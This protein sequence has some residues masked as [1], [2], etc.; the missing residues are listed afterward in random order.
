MSITLAIDSIGVLNY[1]FIQSG[2][3]LINSITVTNIGEEDIENLSIVLS[4][5]FGYIESFSSSIPAVASQSFHEVHP[6]LSFHSKLI[7]ELTERVIDQLTCTVKREEEVLTQTTL[8]IAVLPIQQWSGTTVIPESLACYALPN[9]PEV[10]LIVARAAE[11]LKQ[12]TGNPSFTGYLSNDKNRVLEQVSAIYAAIYELNIVYSVLPASF[13]QVGQR[14]RLPNEVY[15]IKQA[16]CIEMSLLFSSVCE[17][18]GLHPFITVITGHAFA[19]VWLNDELFDSSLVLDR[20]ELTK[21]LAKGINDLEIFE[22]TC[23]NQASGK[24]FDQAIRIAHRHLENPENFHFA[25]DI[26]RCHLLGL[27]PLPVKSV[28]NGEIT[29]IDYGYAKDVEEKSQLKQKL[30]D[31]FLDTSQKE[32]INKSTIWMRNLLDLSRRNALISFRPNMKSLQLFTSDLDSLEDALSNGDSFTLTE[33]TGSLKVASKSNRMLD[34]ENEKEFIAEIS[35]ADFKAKMIRTFMEENDMVSVLKSIYRENQKSIEENG[36]S[37]LF[38]ALGFLKWF[39]PKEN[40]SDGPNFRYAP[41]VLVPIDLTRKSLTRYQIRLRDEDSQMNITLLEY[42]RQQFNLSINGLNPLPE[43]EAG[44]DI[45]LIFNSIRKAIIQQKGWDILDTAVLG[46]FSFSQFVMW[47]DLKERFDQLTSNKVVKGLVD[48]IYIEPNRKRIDEED[49]DKEFEAKELLIPSPVDSSQ[50]AAIAE[51]NSQQSFVLHGPPGTGKSQTITNMIANSLYHGKSILFVA[52][53][54]AALNVVY[55]RLAQIGLEDFCLEIHSNKTSKRVVL[56]K[57]EHSLQ[58]KPDKQLSQFTKLGQQVQGVRKK[59]NQQLSELHL[60]RAVGLSIYELISALDA[61]NCDFPRLS[62]N[63]SQLLLLNA[64]SL[65]Q[66]QNQLTILAT[67]LAEATHPYHS[68]P[69]KDFTNHTYSSNGESSLRKCIENL[70]TAIA[71]LQPYCENA[72]LTQLSVFRQ[73]H[74]VITER[75]LKT[76]LSENSWKLLLDPDYFAKLQS[77]I[78]SNIEFSQLKKKIRSRYSDDIHHINLVA[79]RTDYTK[80]IGRFLM[81]KGK[82]KQALLPLNV[83]CKNGFSLSEDNAEQEFATLAQYLDLYKEKNT[84]IQQFETLVGIQLDPL[85]PEDALEDIEALFTKIYM[86][87]EEYRLSEDSLYQHYCNVLKSDSKNREELLQNLDLVENE[88][89]QFFQLTNYSLNPFFMQQEGCNQLVNLFDTWS[90]ALTHWKDWSHLNQTFHSIKELGLSSLSDELRTLLINQQITPTQIKDGCLQAIQHRLIELYIQKSPTLTSFNRLT[91]QNAIDQYNT[92]LDKVEDESKKQIRQALISRIP[93]TE[94]ASVEQQKQLAAIQKIIRSKG[95]GTSIRKIFQENGSIIKQLTPCLLMSPLSVAQ[96][97]DLDFPKFDLVIFDEASQIPTG[98]AIGAMSRADNC[99]IVGDPKQMPPTA[100]FSNQ[101]LDEENIQLEDLESL[102][103]DCLAI[104]MPQKYLSCHYRS[105]SESLISFSNRMYYGNKMMTFPSP[106]DSQSKV[107]LRSIDGIYKRG[108]SRTN[109]QEAEAIV[110][111]IR[112]R[113]EGPDF[114]QESI[115]VVTFNSTQQELI[116]DLLQKLF[117]EQPELEKRAGQMAEPIFI[118]NLENVQG[119][120]RD[121]IL[122][123]ITYGPDAD[124]KFYQNFGPLGK[125]GGW[126]RLNVAVSRARKEMIVFSSITS[127]DISVVA[128]TSE[129]VIGLKTFLKFAKTGLD[130]FQTKKTEKQTHEQLLSTIQVFLAKKGYQSQLNFGASRF[131]LDLVVEHPTEKGTFLATILLDGHQLNQLHTARDRNRLLPTI[132]SAK[133]WHTFRIWTL[134]YFENQERVLHDLLDFLEKIGPKPA[135][136]APNNVPSHLEETR[137][138]PHEQEPKLTQVTPICSPVTRTA[139]VVSQPI[140]STVQ[141]EPV[142]SLEP[143]KGSQKQNI[144]EETYSIYQ[145]IESEQLSIKER[146]PKA[147]TALL[148]RIVD[149]EA[150]ILEELVMKRAIELSTESK[151]TANLRDYLQAG[152][153]KVKSKKTKED[154]TTVYFGQLDPKTYSSF[155]TPAGQERRDFYLIPLV[156]IANAMEYSLM[157]QSDATLEKNLFEDAQIISDT[158][159]LFGFART[160]E[161]MS[162]RAEAALQNLAKKKRIK[163]NRNKAT[164]HI[165]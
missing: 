162:L 52:E 40:S 115:G 39:D 102:L 82:V 35:R 77:I 127:E 75:N 41:L 27:R 69:L 131:Q 38:L 7:F 65:D 14:L 24:S 18:V 4:S 3:P 81:K 146:E 100:F 93:D 19:G 92:L 67:Q 71:K 2:I 62:L 17:N 91:Q 12:K 61:N 45:R 147:L 148:Q 141:E 111:E 28:E 76:N 97:I 6:R 151:L 90:A 159:R 142:S 121:S 126:R 154:S 10:S 99:I 122:F 59:L 105:K 56:D 68:H 125:K 106:S 34:I 36:A 11:L 108:E 158:V 47:N 88:V 89:V 156:E 132:L 83:L 43:D 98:I 5:E 152:L 23:M 104:N 118:K 73:I 107:S 139:L 42:L 46:H 129:G 117:A 25:I 8:P 55:Q 9:I 58:L 87:K 86:A 153:K 50:L 124:G 84:S 144:L 16:N 79:I 137:Q 37:S 110:Q 143:S 101:K 53:K 32:A 140:E 44:V 80:A 116:D 136:L 130:T 120:E 123:S 95:R 78:H 60:P 26:H 112:A 134:D 165:L 72:P 155:R 54:M 20:S 150:P 114:Q 85:D 113:L 161:N 128:R 49:L 57:F 103:E 51:A 135:S 1:S 64:D 66:L 164:F 149:R 22:A 70:R 29:I 96:Y 30:A 31:Y 145:E 13:E 15:T 119:D 160:T 157:N 33:V 138:T 63:D 48:G 109:P 74:Q 133:Q 163:R 94:T 21:R